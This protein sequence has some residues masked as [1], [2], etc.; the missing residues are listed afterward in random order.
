MKTKPETNSFKKILGDIET[1]WEKIS[2]F[3]RYRFSEL[4]D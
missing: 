2:H 4:R 1:N 3:L